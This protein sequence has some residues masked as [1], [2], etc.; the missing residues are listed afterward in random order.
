MNN[1]E[2][3][4]LLKEAFNTH[5]LMSKREYHTINEL[6]HCLRYDEKFKELNINIS[7]EKANGE[8]WAIPTIDAFVDIGTLGIWFDDDKVEFEHEVIDDGGY[9]FYC[10]NITIY[11]R[12][13][14]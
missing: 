13:E 6:L 4:T 12:E 10:D 9:L 3:K 1:E 5:M 2:F 8:W 11:E 14:K 7:I